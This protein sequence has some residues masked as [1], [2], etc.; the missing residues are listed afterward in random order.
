[1]KYTNLKIENQLCFPLYVCSK[2]IIR[3]YKPFLDKIDLTYTQYITMLVLWENDNINIKTL[4]KKLFLDSGT[5]TPLL[6]KLENK[7]L[8]TRNK[9]NF[10]ERNMIISLTNKGIKLQEQ[11]KNIPECIGKCI[12]I[13]QKD[14]ITLY[15]LLYKIL[16]DFK[17]E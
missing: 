15:E 11:A 13:S 4:G 12:N 10:D 17:N 14:A 7:N 8:I 5:L 6:K 9:N 2:E 16:G 1:M 3:K